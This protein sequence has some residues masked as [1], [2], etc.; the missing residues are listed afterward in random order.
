MS[1]GALRFRVRGSA[2]D[3]YDLIAEGSGASFRIFCR[4]PAGDRGGQMCRHAAALLMGEVGDVVA[5]AD[6]II[7]LAGMAAGSSALARAVEHRPAARHAPAMHL[8]APDDLATS[9]AEEIAALRRAG[10]HVDAGRAHVRVHAMA[11]NGIRPL[12]HPVLALVFDGSCRV[13][14]QGLGPI[15]FK[16]PGRAAHRFAEQ[17]RLLLG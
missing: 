9:M 17:V 6:H 15:R 7:A 16:D 3:L 4:C 10:W 14:R 8:P 2:G 5:G 12:K 13:E 1:D 11:K